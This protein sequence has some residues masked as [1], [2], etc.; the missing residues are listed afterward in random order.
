MA[1]LI[2]MDHSVVAIEIAV[3]VATSFAHSQCDTQAFPVGTIAAVH[4]LSRR[5]VTPA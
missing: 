4:D 3:D 1:T 2:V 5:Y